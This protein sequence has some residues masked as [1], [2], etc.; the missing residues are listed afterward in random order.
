MVKLTEV[1][2][3]ETNYI[4]FLSIITITLTAPKHVSCTDTKD[5]MK[6]EK[7]LNNMDIVELCF[8]DNQE[9]P[10]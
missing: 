4:S 1:I 9:V 10:G 6:L 5:L 7:Q 8:H 3:F 2:T